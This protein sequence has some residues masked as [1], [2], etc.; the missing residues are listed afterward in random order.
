MLHMVTCVSTLKLLCTEGRLK[1]YP[2]YLFYLV[3]TFAPAQNCTC[4]TESR[5]NSSINPIL[6]WVWS[7]TNV[8]IICACIFSVI[9]D[10][11]MANLKSKERKK[12]TGLLFCSCGCAEFWALKLHAN[13]IDSIKSWMTPH[14][15]TSPSVEMYQIYV[16]SVYVYTAMYTYE[17]ICMIY[18]SWH[19]MS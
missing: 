10:Q 6:L 17:Y 3:F 7:D 11:N 1:Y 18:R 2:T 8:G 12:A 4:G 19:L 14:Y 5:N 15:P 16:R 13:V 9:Q